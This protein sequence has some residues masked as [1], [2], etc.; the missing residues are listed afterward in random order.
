MTL[1]KVQEISANGTGTYYCKGT[2]ELEYE[3]LEANPSNLTVKVDFEGVPVSFSN[4]NI[5][6]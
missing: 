5:K 1:T 2:M 4:I 3:N 6:I